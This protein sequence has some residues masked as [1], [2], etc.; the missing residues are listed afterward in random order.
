MHVFA[1]H[2]S[3]LR[4]QL[5]NYK[6]VNYSLLFAHKNCKLEIVLRPKGQVWVTTMLYLAPYQDAGFK[7]NYITDS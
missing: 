6:Y 7:P 3:R 2:S 1:G 5:A 4:R